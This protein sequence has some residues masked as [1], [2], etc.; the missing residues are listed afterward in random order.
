MDP[1]RATLIY[2][3]QCAFCRRWVE[4]VRRWDR[5]RRI[6]VVPYQADDLEVRF[7]ELSRAE[8]A[9]RIHLIDAAGAVHRG[10]AA[11]REVLARL[12]AGWLWALPLRCPGALRIADPIYEW[13]T[14]H[15]GPVPQ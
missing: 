4:R 11:G 8:C 7:P 13:I 2:D 14:R 10:A 5:H 12:P 15:Y 3:G 6:D 9:L 1:G